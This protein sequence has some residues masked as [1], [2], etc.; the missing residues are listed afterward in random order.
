[1][2]VTEEQAKGMWCPFARVAAQE[3][4]GNFTVSNRAMD[5]GNGPW[6]GDAHMC[7]STAC[8]AWRW[9]AP[10]GTGGP[11]CTKGFCG[12]AGKPDLFRIGE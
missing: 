6:I 9:R 10:H 8:M 5:N 4:D 2:W 11:V 12:L 7:I 3:H 1:M